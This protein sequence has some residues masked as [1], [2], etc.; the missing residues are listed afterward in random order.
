M[1]RGLLWCKTGVLLVRA[2]GERER[3]EGESVC[4]VCVSCVCSLGSACVF[5]S[6]KT[7]WNWRK[8]KP[9]MREAYAEVEERD[10][11]GESSKQMLFLQYASKSYTSRTI[12]GTGWIL[13]VVL[14]E[15]TMLWKHQLQEL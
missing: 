1:K 3:V 8:D 15:C 7:I 12:G 2:I 13:C 6:E 5:C 11:Q 4:S 14:V 10:S 9:K